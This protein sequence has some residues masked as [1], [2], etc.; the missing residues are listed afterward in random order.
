M[1]RKVMIPEELLRDLCL[2]HLGDLRDPDLVARIREGLEKKL[3]AAA[4]REEYSRILA[5]ENTPP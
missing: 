4:R 5:K 3:A 2:Y 1:A